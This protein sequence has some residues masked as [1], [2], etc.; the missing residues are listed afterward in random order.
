VFILP[1]SPE[2]LRRRLEER[3]QDAADVIERRLRAA[4][5]ELAHV[6]EFDYV[7]INQSFDVAVADLVSIVRSQRLRMT[8]QL[9]RNR[10]L[11]NRLK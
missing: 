1:P 7:I 11:I 5:E 9:E 2:A 8:T 6:E 10:D 3:G 4:R